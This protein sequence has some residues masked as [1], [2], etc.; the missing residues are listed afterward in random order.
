MNHLRR[1]LLRG[2]GAAG[3]LAVAAAAGL[4][5]P[6]QVLASEWNK[7]GFG[8]TTAEDALKS[9]GATA[10]SNSNDILIK[11]PDIAENGAVVPIE[12]TSKIPGTQS[13]ALVADKNPFPLVATFN[14]ENGAEGY[15]HVRIKMGQSSNIRAIV[16]AGGKT[17]AAV[18]EVKVTIGGCGG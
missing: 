1:A 9:I 4:L 11:A 17:Y 14:V 13:I 7:T 8:A 18:K 6:T 5:K 2:T 10:S 15:V 3:A 16:N 12:I